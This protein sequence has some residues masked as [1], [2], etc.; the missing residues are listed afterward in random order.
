[1]SNTSY[2]LLVKLNDELNGEQNK[3][4][5]WPLWWRGTVVS[6]FAARIKS[7]ARTRY[8]SVTAGQHEIKMNYLHLSP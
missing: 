4:A 2:I 7:S 3:G 8:L 1:M 6:A 5:P